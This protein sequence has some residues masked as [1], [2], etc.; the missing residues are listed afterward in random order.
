MVL[1]EISLLQVLVFDVRSE[2]YIWSGKNADMAE[3][4]IGTK[5]AHE[6][7]K[8]GYKSCWYPTGM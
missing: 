5:L 2:V 4:R 7:F 1:N 3:K 8:G 6:L